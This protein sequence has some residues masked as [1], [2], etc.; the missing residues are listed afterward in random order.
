MTIDSN[1]PPNAAA[2]IKAK[3]RKLKKYEALP[4]T[5]YQSDGAI[6]MDFFSPFGPMIAKLTFPSALINKLNDFADDFYEEGVR[7][8]FPQ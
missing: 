4:Q 2:S 1:L 8:I 7:L 6:P 5:V 3:K